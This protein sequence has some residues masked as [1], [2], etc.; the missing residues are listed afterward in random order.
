MTK[1][2]IAEKL[3][4]REERLDHERLA[5]EEREELRDRILK[6]KKTATIEAGGS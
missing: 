5:T 2:T 3:R 4:K 1:P 6:L